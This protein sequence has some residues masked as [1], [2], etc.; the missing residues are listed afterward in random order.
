MYRQDT[1]NLRCD[2]LL[3][4]IS[5]LPGVVYPLLNIYKKMC[6]RRQNGSKPLTTVW[7]TDMDVDGRKHVAVR[8]AA[9]RYFC[10]F[11]TR[12]FSSL[13]IALKRLI[14]TFVL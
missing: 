6:D 14:R 5:G 8:D 1:R 7:I 2:F 3:L 10:A 12:M 11:G 9:L 4:D 13:K